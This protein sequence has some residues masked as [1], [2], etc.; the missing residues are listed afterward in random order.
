MT[1]TLQLNF[2]NNLSADELHELALIVRDNNTTL[3]RV[4]YEAAS[5]RA[6]KAKATRNSNSQP[7][8]VAA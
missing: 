1:A 4:I 7:Q 6:Q 2:G 5:E 3:E 8:E